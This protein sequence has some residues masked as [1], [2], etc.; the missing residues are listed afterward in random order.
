MNEEKGEMFSLVRLME[1]HNEH[2]D[3]RDEIDVVVKDQY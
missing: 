3:W 2:V 1:E